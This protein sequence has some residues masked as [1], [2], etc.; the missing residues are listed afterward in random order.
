MV[1]FV[2]V[3]VASITAIVVM[4]LVFAIVTL[5]FLLSSPLL[6][7]HLLYRQMKLAI[8]YGGKATTWMAMKKRRILGHVNGCERPACRKTK[9]AKL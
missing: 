4:F 8:R 6:C 7:F 5:L 1:V 9:R 3:F 2:F